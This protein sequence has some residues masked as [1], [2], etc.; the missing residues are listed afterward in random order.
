MFISQWLDE[1]MADGSVSRIVAMREMDGV[2][3]AVVEMPD[4]PALFYPEQNYSMTT[5]EIARELPSD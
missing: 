2:R 5:G 1:D 3:G 4:G